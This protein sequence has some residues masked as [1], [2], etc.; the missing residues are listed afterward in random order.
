MYEAIWQ[1]HT[2]RDPFTAEPISESVREALEQAARFEFTTMR[3]L[4][5]GEAATVL[6]MSA[7]ASTEL[8]NDIDHRIELQRWIATNSKRRRHSG[9]RTA[10]HAQPAASTG[11]RRPFGGLSGDHQADS[12]LREVP[13]TCRADHWIRRAGRLDPRGPGAAAGSAHRHGAW[14]VGVGPVPVDRAQGHAR[15][16]CPGMAVAGEPPDR[17]QIRLPQAVTWRA[18]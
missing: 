5:S 14:P 6:D 13:A 1:R 7:Q 18:P 10:V 12:R 8:A 4:S 15:R 3:M 2:N 9:R 16:G 11:P 17:D